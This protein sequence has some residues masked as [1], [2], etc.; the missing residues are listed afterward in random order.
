VN[1]N[2]DPVKYINGVP[3]SRVQQIHLAGHTDYGD[4]II[5]THDH[6]VVESV[7]DLYAQTLQCIG[8]VTTMIER[9]D[10]FPPFD[11]LMAELEHA[12]KI[13]EKTQETNKCIA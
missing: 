8:P 4:F 11:E 5:D 7:W 9:D 13:A 3:A 10:N 2:F 12:R 6:P 1:H